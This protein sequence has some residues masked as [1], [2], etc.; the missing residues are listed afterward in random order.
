[1]GTDGGIYE[2]FDLGQSWKF[3]ANLPVTQFYKVS[4]DYDEPFYNIY[5]GTQDNNTQGGPSRTQN[6][7]GITNSDWF[8]AL[9]GDGHQPAADPGNSLCDDRTQA[10]Y[11]WRLAIGRRR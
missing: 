3:A 5:G 2:S 7:N 10:T 4:V 8:V 6:I 9:G 11:G 1:M